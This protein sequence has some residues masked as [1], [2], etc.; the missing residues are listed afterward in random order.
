M[1]FLNLRPITLLF[2]PLNVF[3]VT[4]DTEKTFICVVAQGHMCGDLS[5]SGTC[6]TS[7]SFFCGTRKN[8]KYKIKAKTKIWLNADLS[9]C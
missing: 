8:I 1:H 6:P 9:L 7:E 2:V 3:Y 5:I 4:K